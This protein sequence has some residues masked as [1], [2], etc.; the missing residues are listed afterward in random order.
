[1]WS[2]SSRIAENGA[3]KDEEDLVLAALQRSPTYVRARTSIFRGID[4]EVSLVDV[5]KMKAEEKKQVLDVLINAINEDTEMFFKRVK[6][7]FEK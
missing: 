6:E 4:G 3:R 2:S 1:M 5:G 7:R